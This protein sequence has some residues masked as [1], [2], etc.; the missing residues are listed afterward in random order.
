MERHTISQFKY[1]IRSGRGKDYEKIKQDTG[2]ESE[3]RL[4]FGASDQG[5]PL[6]ISGI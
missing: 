2:I 5:N 1:N 6:Y 3:G 4:L